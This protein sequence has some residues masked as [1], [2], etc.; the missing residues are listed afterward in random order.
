MIN[1]KSALIAIE[2]LPE[3]FH[4]D[5]L[6]DQ[7][8]RYAKV[9]KGFKDIEEGRVISQSDLEKLIDTW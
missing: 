7:L 8:L 3:E 4:L 6:I 1:K 5:D 9:E 2:N